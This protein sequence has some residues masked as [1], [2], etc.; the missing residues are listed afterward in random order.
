M[1]EKK[2]FDESHV[3]CNDCL[4]YWHD[5]CDG[6][7]QEKPCTAYVASKRTDLVLRTE[8]LEHNDKVNHRAIMWIYA[9]L[10]LHLLTHLLQSLG[11]I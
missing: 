11:V 6:T 9:I 7:K 2:I 3:D 4:H 1:E 8:R 5:T 10:T